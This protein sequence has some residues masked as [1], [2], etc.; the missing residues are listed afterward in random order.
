[1]RISA[2]TRKVDEGLGTDLP[3][4]IKP[5]A[6]DEQDEHVTNGGMFA[7]PE[8]MVVEVPLTSTEKE[9][10]MYNR[11]NDR[12]IMKRMRTRRNWKIKRYQKCL[13]AV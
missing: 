3:E 12:G 10:L 4:V 8:Y 5:F 9:K 2:Y 1:M 13:S 7:R 6:E 11:A